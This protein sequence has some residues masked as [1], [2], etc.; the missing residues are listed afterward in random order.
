MPVKIYVLKSGDYNLH[1]VGLWLNLDV[2]LNWIGDQVHS[3]NERT[4]ETDLDV[5]MK[6]H[7]VVV[8][9]SDG[10]S[11]EPIDWNEIIPQE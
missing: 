9:P 1:I 5:F 4:D 3:L 10:G 6:K 7:Q 2:M 11:G 8:Y